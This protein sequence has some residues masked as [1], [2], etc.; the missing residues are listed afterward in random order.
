MR[1]ILLLTLLLSGLLSCEDLDQPMTRN[2]TEAAFWKTEQDALDA[3]SSAYENMYHSDYF[4]GNEAL[5]DNGY[6]KSTSFEGVGQ[7]ASGSYD[8]RTGRV[9]SEWGYHYSAI[10][11]C[12][13]VIE[14]VDRISGATDEMI[15]RIKAEARFIRAF[16]L[17][18]LATW[19]GDVPLVTTVITLSEA[20]SLTRTP[21]AEVIAFVLNELSDIQAHLPVLYNEANRGR[22]TKAAAIGMRARVSLYEGNWAE[23][24]LDCEKLIHSTENGEFEL[25]ADYAGL[26]TVAAEYNNEIIL[27]IQFG[28]SRLQST[29]RFFLPQ[30]VGKLRS[31]LVPTRSLVDNYVT[32]NGKAITDPASGYDVN[33]P[34]VN[35]DPRLGATI[36]HHNSTIVDFEGSTQTILTHPG[37]DPAINTIEDQGA[38][39]TGYYFRKYYDPTAVNYNSGLNLILLRYADILLM[40][41]EA[42]NESGTFTADIWN[43]TIKPIRSRAGFTEASA[44]EFD[45]TLAQE[46]WRE[47]IRRER[48][49]ELAF[50]GLRVFDI[51]RWQIADEVLNEPVRGIKVSG[52]FPQ[53]E[54]GFLIVEDRLFQ[55]PRHYLWPVPQHELDQNENLYPNNTGW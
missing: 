9:A 14:N 24:I 55:D 5:S 37:S 16:S 39:A 44:L 4:F 40:Y 15:N 20:T 28:G 25:Y 10:R 8:A 41:A 22:I 31:N 47:V 13:M 21:H 50:E 1:R 2:F 36:I 12:N 51:R 29:Q 17:F 52:Q 30:T 6:N 54:N 32:L 49:T 26:F 18:H 3:L 42:K 27:A 34:Y 48:R 33:D 43:Q 46:T 7:I 35:R 38:S 23:V 53:D 11:K 19:Y 45:A